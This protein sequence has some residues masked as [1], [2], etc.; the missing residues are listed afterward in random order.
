MTPALLVSVLGVLTIVAI[1]FCWAR[2][3]EAHAA[4]REFPIV[5]KDA[6]R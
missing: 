3:T 2:K 6:R 5:S 4:S 1:Y